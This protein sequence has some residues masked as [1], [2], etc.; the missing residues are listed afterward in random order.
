MNS[1]SVLPSQLI[2]FRGRDD[3]LISWKIY[4][5]VN[6]LILILHRLRLL[7]AQ[8][9]PC[10]PSSFGVRYDRERASYAS[11]GAMMS[12]IHALL[13]RVTTISF[14]IFAFQNQAFLP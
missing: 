9:A 12:E 11:A 2:Q 5:N 8:R 1:R 10:S 14:V 6:L 13:L 4:V 7:V 3:Q